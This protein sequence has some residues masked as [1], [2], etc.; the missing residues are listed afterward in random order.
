MSNH[1]L[2][3]QVRGWENTSQLAAANGR[4]G[5]EGRLLFLGEERGA[6]LSFLLVLA[7]RAGQVTICFIIF[8]QAC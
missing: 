1:Q 8:T 7:Q 4:F 3:F 5:E 2:G 6:D